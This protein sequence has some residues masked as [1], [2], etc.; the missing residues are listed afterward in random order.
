M[1]TITTDGIVRQRKDLEQLLLSGGS[2]MEKKV[3]KIVR[4]VLDEVRKTVSASAKSAMQSDPRQ[5]Y[6]AVK[7]AVYRRIL[8]GSV[9]LLDKRKRG[10]SGHAPAIPGGKRTGRGGNRIS[11]SAR[12]QQVMSYWGEERGFILRFINAGTQ[13][14]EAGSRGGSL[15]GN[16]GSISARHFF[17]SSSRAAMEKAAGHLSQLIDEQIRQELK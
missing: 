5:A 8:G 12:T 11:R 14:R 2:A 7:T 4:K 6:R 17:S 16:R 13:Q 1:D 10:G 15:H 9:S 3:Q